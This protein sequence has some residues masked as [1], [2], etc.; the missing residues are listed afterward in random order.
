MEKKQKGEQF[1]ILDP[2]RLPEKPVSPNM[3][4]LFFLVLAAGLVFGAGLVKLLDFFD[5]SLREPEYFEADLGLPVLAT[6]PRI[7][8]P[9]EMRLRKLNRMLTGVA[10]IIA[11]GLFVGFATL[12]FNGPEMTIQAVRSLARM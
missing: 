3:R 5:M 2:A 7:L 1:S 12:T 11:L 8:H 6:V 10:I 9:K 4:K